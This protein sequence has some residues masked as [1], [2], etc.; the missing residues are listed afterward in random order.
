[1]TESAGNPQ[2]LL[3]TPATTF[4]DEDGPADEPIDAFTA[5]EPRPRRAREGLPPGF[6]MRHEK[7]YVD[8]LSAAPTI[9]QVAITEIDRDRIDRDQINADDDPSPAIDRLVDSIRRAGILQP[10]L[11][12]SRLGRFRLIDGHRRLDAASLAGLR[13]VP[14]IV[15]D[16]DEPAIEQMRRQVNVRPPA[17]EPIVEAGP[18]LPA[19]AAIDLARR[20]ERAHAQAAIGTSRP[21]ADLLD[22]E[23][24]QAGRL[25]RAAAVMLD[26]PRLQRRELSARAVVDQAAVATAVQ[27]RLS[28]VQLT[29]TIGDPEFQ[30]PADPALVTQA[31]AGAI[32]AL[33]AFVDEPGA[34]L[35]LSVHC[36]KTRPAMI[37]E[38]AQ[39][40]VSVEPELMGQFFDVDSIVHPG[41]T[42]TALLLAAAARIVRGHGGRA[43]VRRD[44]PVGCTVTFVLPQSMAR[45]DA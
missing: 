41:G 42:A 34:A 24:A 1:V 40:V 29:T 23:L 16:L 27:R 15:H 19:S 44:D 45:F 30:V 33:S 43:D 7:H 38:L 37:I 4:V 14:C 8:D 12:A 13:H 22:S 32:D 17:P 35:T 21:T 6:R 28:G 26:T 18:A 39:R 5:D 20:I 25:A 31:L 36:V 2:D 11:V 3:S 9:R 10:L